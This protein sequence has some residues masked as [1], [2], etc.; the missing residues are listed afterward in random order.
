MPPENRMQMQPSIRPEVAQA[1]RLIFEHLPNAGSLTVQFVEV[2]GIVTPGNEHK[3]VGILTVTKPT[4][5]S[6]AKLGKSRKMLFLI[7]VFEARAKVTP[8]GP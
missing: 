2:G 6:M 1:L 7:V 4:M 3:T 8:H 5:T